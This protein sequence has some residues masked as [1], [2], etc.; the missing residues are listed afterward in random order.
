MSII[1]GKSPI[2]ISQVKKLNIDPSS[3]RKLTDKEKAQFEK[4]H[5]MAYARP[6][7]L[8]EL[9]NHVSQKIYA[10]VKV[11]GQTIATVY[12]GGSSMTSNA[13][14]GKIN[15]IIEQLD[16]KLT[17]PDG[18]QERAE[19]IAKAFGG[20]VVKAKTAVTQAQYL[21]TP[22]F[23][24][25]YE[26]DYEAM[27]AALGRVATPQTAVDTQSL[28]IDEPSDKSVV[29]EFLDFTEMS[30]KEK[31]RAMILKTMGL[32]EE[33][34]AAMSAENREK[35]E[36]KIKE[37]IEEQIEKKTGMTLTRA[38]IATV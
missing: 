34:L 21:S 6:T 32:K 3:V 28:D 5:E 38:A 33:D 13:L 12:N 35:I 23:T 2:D 1:S 4:I 26:V 11:N 24:V 18:A 29:D 25:K 19:A 15:K 27:N 31:V 36:A 30:W 16:S 37:K 17:G 14:G 20:T 9:K 7:N 22:T 10:E 8:D